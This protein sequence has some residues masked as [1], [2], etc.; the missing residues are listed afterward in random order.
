MGRA[1]SSKRVF[2]ISFEKQVRYLCEVYISSASDTT[3][4]GAK[5]YLSVR[6]L[7]NAYHALYNNWKVGEISE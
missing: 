5:I 4:R 2:I 1:R 7:Q 6:G 3:I